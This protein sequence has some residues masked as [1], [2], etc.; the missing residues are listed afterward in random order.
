M[1]LESHP[2]VVGATGVQRDLRGTP[3]ARDG[4]DTDGR[5][6]TQT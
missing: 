2:V 6:E 1:N 4:G 5:D 3:F